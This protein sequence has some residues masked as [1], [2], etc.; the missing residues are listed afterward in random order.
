M[1]LPFRG[2]PLRN[3]FHFPFKLQHVSLCMYDPRCHCQQHSNTGT[4]CDKFVRI[5]LRVNPAVC[6]IVVPQSCAGCVNGVLDV[7]RSVPIMELTHDDEHGNA[8]MS[9]F[10][11]W[12][13]KEW[14]QLVLPSST[15]SFPSHSTFAAALP[16]HFRSGLLRIYKT[17]KNGWLPNHV[18]LNG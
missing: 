14:F 1:K 11:V 13:A 2:P 18:F 3:P 17:P 4:C 5:L 10:L 6:P 7:V 15:P 16:F 8:H 9:D 12:L